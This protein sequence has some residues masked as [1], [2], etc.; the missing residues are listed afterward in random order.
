MKILPIN[1]HNLRESISAI[2]EAVKVLQTG[3]SVVY[4]TDTIYGLGVDALNAEA[5]SRLF[6]IKRRP[7][8]KAMPVI[9]AN[10][11]MARKIAY[12]NDKKMKILEK[13][14]SVS[15]EKSPG[16]ITVVLHKKDVIPD[17]LT[18]LKNTV[19]IRIPNSELAKTLVL[20]LG[21]P[22]TAT[23]ANISGEEPDTNIQKIIRRFNQTGI[24][25]NLILDAGIL[26]KSEPST[27]LDMTND[28]YKILRVGPVKK[29]QLLDILSI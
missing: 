3:G 28:N 15:D 27:V 2:E 25:P 20:S 7:A 6:K 10:I 14:W 4:P 24:E 19:G 5:I 17:I 23:S 8:E 29:E 26:P 21:S 22:I 16:P 12:I 9:V 18:G 13:L 11:E 1:L